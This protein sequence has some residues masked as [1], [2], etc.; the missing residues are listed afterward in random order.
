MKFMLGFSTG[1]IT[2]LAALYFN[3]YIAL[4][5]CFITGLTGGHRCF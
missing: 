4:W 1:I 2:M 5:P 3:P